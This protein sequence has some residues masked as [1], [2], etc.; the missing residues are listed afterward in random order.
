MMGEKRR[1]VELS[2]LMAI[3]GLRLK[4]NKGKRGDRWGKAYEV[5]LL[6]KKHRTYAIGLH[7]EAKGI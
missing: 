3:G 7:V 4:G 2:N 1:G 5:G 6:E